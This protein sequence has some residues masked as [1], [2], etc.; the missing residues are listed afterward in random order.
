VYTDTDIVFLVSSVLS[1]VMVTFRLRIDI[2]SECGTWV[3]GRG[4]Q[5]RH[6]QSLFLCHLFHQNFQMD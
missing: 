2:M 3:D 1:D 6:E 4:K 5:K